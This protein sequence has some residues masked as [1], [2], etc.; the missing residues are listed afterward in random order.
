MTASTSPLVDLRL[1]TSH[2]A[3][4]NSM[5]YERLRELPADT[6][7]APHAGRPPGMT[8]IPGM[9]AHIYVVGLIWKAHL[10]GERHGF[11]SRALDKLPPLPE[12][13]ALQAQV[14]RWYVDYAEREP[15]E[16]LARVIDFSFIDGGAG[17]LR[18]A[19][20]L[21]HVVTHAVYHRGFVGD[22]LYAAGVR[23]PTTDLP[24]YLRDVEPV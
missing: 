2:C 5:F 6:L 16:R 23:P 14:D 18:A 12:L 22:M 1:L 4:A 24:V 9:M 11:T 8:T 7:S 17:R 21:L 15:D 20:M 19:D 3:W 10:T 13:A